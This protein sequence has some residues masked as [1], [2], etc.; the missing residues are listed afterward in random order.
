M[1]KAWLANLVSISG[2][3]PDA[4][5]PTPGRPGPGVPVRGSRDGGGPVGAAVKGVRLHPA[6]RGAACYEPWRGFVL[7]ICLVFFYSCLT[8]VSLMR[9]DSVEEPRM[10]R[11]W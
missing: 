6:A 11:D 7:F 1:R 5:P 4:A 3:S 8:F 10:V 9:V 2:A